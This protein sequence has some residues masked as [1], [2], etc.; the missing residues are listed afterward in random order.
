MTTPQKAE[1]SRAIAGKVHH[2]F[3]KRRRPAAEKGPEAGRCRP[4]RRQPALPHQRL[5]LPGLHRDDESRRQRQFLRHLQRH[6]R[7]SRRQ[8]AGERLRRGQPLCRHAGHALARGAGRAE[9]PAHRAGAHGR[10]QPAGCAV[11]PLCRHLCRG[12][13]DHR[14]R[15]RRLRRRGGSRPGGRRDRGGHGRQLRL[16]Q[17]HRRR[18]QGPQQPGSARGATAAAGSA[19]RHRQTGGPGAVRPRRLCAALGRRSTPPPWCRRSCPAR[20]P[21]A[22]WPTCWTAPS[23][24]AAI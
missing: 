7:R 3:E 20:K 17:R 16:G 21:G 18:G 1:L 12:L 4:P 19:V 14:Q 11:R 13:Q 22:W 6:G 24:P 23:T 5:Y 15:H 2:P 8:Q 9:R 10:A